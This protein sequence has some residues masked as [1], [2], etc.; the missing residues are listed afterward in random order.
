M[1][2]LTLL[3]LLVSLPSFAANY[4]SKTSSF[5]ISSIGPAGERVY[6]NCDS[7]ERLVES[8]LSAL[9][10]KN[11]KVRCSGG[12]DTIGRIHMPAFVRA[13]YDAVS[14]QIAG[15]INTEAQTIHFQDR[16]GCHLNTQVYKGLKKN[17]EIA[18]EAVSRCSKSSSRTDIKL[19]VIKE[20]K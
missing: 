14:T 2:I 10:A 18:S 11:I 20:T 13:E 4:A 9:G 6:Y 17:F 7:V 15:D 19:I 12:I 16:E 8:T 3:A 1:K 5:S